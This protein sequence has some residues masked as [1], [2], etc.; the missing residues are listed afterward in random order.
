M[1]D[2]ALNVFG[3]CAA[4]CLHLPPQEEE[5]ITSSLGDR[6]TIYT[7]GTIASSQRTPGINKK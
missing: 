7:P 5:C 6:R 2:K 1:A 3:V 4:K